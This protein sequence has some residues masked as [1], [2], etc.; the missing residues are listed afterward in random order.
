MQEVHILWLEVSIPI[1][2]GNNLCAGREERTEESSY[3]R[4]SQERW[5]TF[6][7]PVGSAWIYSNGIAGRS[8]IL[9]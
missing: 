3:S 9:N 1:W 2:L 8:S 4:M 5:D 7:K 6:V